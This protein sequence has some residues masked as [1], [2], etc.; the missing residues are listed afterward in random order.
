MFF[1]KII[2]IKDKDNKDF[3]LSESND[4]KI[5]IS[6]LSLEQKSSFINDNFSS[7]ESENNNIVEY[8]ANEY[9]L[10]NNSEIESNY[11]EDFYRI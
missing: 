9:N 1:F 7:N 6:D 4:S 3:D 10:F 8:N 5:K 2:K 11:Y